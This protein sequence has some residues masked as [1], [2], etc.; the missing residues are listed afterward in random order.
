MD[1]NKTCY[2]FLDFDGTVFLNGK[3]VPQQTREALAAVQ[4]AGH[5]IIL[6]TG[7]SRGFAPG[8][9]GI[10]WDGEIFGGAD[11]TYRGERHC[12]HRLDPAEAEAWFRS[13]IRRKCWVNVE[14][15]V[16]FFRINLA[17]HEGDYTAKETEALMREYADMTKGNPITKLSVGVTEV[18]GE[19]TAHM[20][21][22][23][24]QTYLELFPEGM[25]K[26]AILAEFCGRYG[27]ERAQCIAFGDSRNDLAAF[28][29][30]PTSV[31]MKG[32][33]EE[34]EALATYRAKTDLGVAEGVKYYFPALFS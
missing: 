8:D 4:R 7:R 15:E 17:K 1:T 19:P 25:D 3:T 14:G 10:P 22:V 21:P 24:Q 16:R 34:L 26:G 23:N 29:F 27:I 12:E 5:Q 9:V 20:N 2:L 32:A 33:P 6:N 28:A 31:S 18:R 30:A 13:A 11:Y